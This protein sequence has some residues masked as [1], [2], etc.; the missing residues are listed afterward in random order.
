MP[1]KSI[2]LNV[3]RGACLRWVVIKLE[4]GCLGT[5]ECD[6]L[7]LHLFKPDIMDMFNWKLR[8]GLVCTNE[9]TGLKSNPD[10]GHSLMGYDVVVSGFRVY[11]LYQ[12]QGYFNLCDKIFFS[13]QCLGLSY[14]S[15]VEFIFRFNWKLETTLSLCSD[16]SIL[17]E[18]RIWLL[19]ALAGGWQV[20]L[21]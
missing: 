9:S 11:P 10:H 3:G 8:N 2:H 1:H 19:H 7:H 13:M 5:Y 6:V 21:C 16:S 12:V 20:F 15:Q 17:S 14:P 4:V 18:P